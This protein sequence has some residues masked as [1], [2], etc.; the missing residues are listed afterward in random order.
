MGRKTRRRRGGVTFKSENNKIQT[1]EIP[2]LSNLLNNSNK[3]KINEGVESYYSNRLPFNSL[4]P[5]RGQTTKR[6]TRAIREARNYYAAHEYPPAVIDRMINAHKGR[7][8]YLTKLRAPLAN[9]RESQN[10][11]VNYRNINIPVAV[12]EHENILH[13]NTLRAIGNYSPENIKIVKD[14]MQRGYNQEI[15]AAAFGHI[16]DSLE[17]NNND[18]NAT[19]RAKFMNAISNTPPGPDRNYLVNRIHQYHGYE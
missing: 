4:I 17:I 9:I 14:I 16:Y 15:L 3:R 10:N 18:T 7:V 8:N 19:I 1:Y 6:E 13:P 11:L 12:M 2:E 5:S